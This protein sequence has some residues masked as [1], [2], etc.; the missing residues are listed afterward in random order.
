M[1]RVETSIRIDLAIG[2]TRFMRNLMLEDVYTPRKEYSPATLGKT[3]FLDGSQY[4]KKQPDHK[5]IGL[6][7]RFF[8]GLL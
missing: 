8:R 5:V 3:P 4:T 7:P 1:G 2:C 6:R